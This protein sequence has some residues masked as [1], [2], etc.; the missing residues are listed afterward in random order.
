MVNSQLII[1]CRR[2]HNAWHNALE[3]RNTIDNYLLSGFD[4]LDGGSFGF[5]SDF[6]ESFDEPELFSVEDDSDLEDEELV[7]DPVFL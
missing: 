5:V 4:G 3:S 1:D 7:E 2:L 6:G